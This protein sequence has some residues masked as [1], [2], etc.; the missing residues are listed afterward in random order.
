V[1]VRA[2]AL[3]SLRG[4]YG[5]LDFYFSDAEAD[6]E[7]SGQNEAVIFDLRSSRALPFRRV[8]AFAASQDR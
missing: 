5:E 2:I 4:D 8:S 3:L 6:L 7:F 1:Q